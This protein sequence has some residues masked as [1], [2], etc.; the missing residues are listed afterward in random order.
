MEVRGCGPSNTLCTGERICVEEACEAA[1]CRTDE[2]H[3]L[4]AKIE[5]TNTKGMPL[6]LNG[7]TPDPYIVL[8]INGIEV[9]RT[10]PIE[11]SFVPEFP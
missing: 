10:K 3:V 4:L 7:G 6:D 2:F 8:E 9:M 5:L 11:D 1:F